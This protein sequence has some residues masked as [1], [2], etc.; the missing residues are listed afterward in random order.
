MQRWTRVTYNECNYRSGLARGSCSWYLTSALAVSS[1]QFR[2][3]S[4]QALSPSRPWVRGQGGQFPGSTMVA[5]LSRV[6]R[7]G[8]RS[9]IFQ[10]FWGYLAMVC[11]RSSQANKPPSA[12]AYTQ[13]SP[14]ADP[15]EARL[16]IHAPAA[17]MLV[18]RRR[19][20]LPC[21]CR[22]PVERTQP[23]PAGYG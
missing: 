15:G 12:L 9:W 20:A 4:R 22:S 14:T 6:A 2:R 11:R 16:V 18:R 17:V 23:N 13:S 3:S 10:C 1:C 5:V 7:Q 8:N 21:Y 19:L